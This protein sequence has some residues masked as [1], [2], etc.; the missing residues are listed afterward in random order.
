MI[1]YLDMDGVLAD[2]DR[3][4]I[5]LIGKR[6]RDFPTSQ[7]GWDAISDYK[8]IYSILDPM[9]DAHE[10]VN[11]ILYYQSIHKFDVGILT[12][13]PKLGRIP[14]AQVHKQQ[15]IS[16]YFP[17]L[18]PNF[19][20]GPHAIDKQNHCKPGDVLID[21]SHLNIPQWL[22]KGGYGIFHENAVSSLNSLRSYLESRY[23]P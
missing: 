20:I 23:G 13:I 21:D 15:W 17:E 6:L 4:T 7:S 11:G 9:P 3:K 16:K 1:V 10:L 2:F 8:H 19:N 18:L 5:E 12:A 14:D 22:E